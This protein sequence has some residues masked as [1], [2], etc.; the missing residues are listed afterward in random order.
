M[1]ITPRQAPSGE[2]APAG[3]ARPEPPLP[4]PPTLST[5]LLPALARPNRRFLIL[6]GIWTVVVAC[7]LGILMYY[8]ELEAR[9]IAVNRARDSYQKDLAYRRWASERGGVYVPLD[10]KTPANPHLAHRPDREI[11]TPQGKV[12]TLVNPAYMTRMVH[13]LGAV[14]YGLKGHITSLHPIRPGNAADPWERKALETF[15]QGV[16][17]ISEIT[18]QDGRRVLRF[19][20]AFL[21]E[22]SCLACHAQQGYRVGQVRGGISVT[23]P[24]GAGPAFAGLTHRSLSLLVLGTFWVLGGLAISAWIRRRRE[25]EAVQ[26]HLIRNLDE[27]S[28]QFE[29]L[30]DTTP[31]GLWF[32]DAE[33]RIRWVNDAYCRLSGYSRSELVG[34]RVS[35]VEAVESQE[36]TIRRIETMRAAPGGHRFRTRHRAKDGHFIHLEVT[37]TFVPS[38]DQI[39]AFL[40]DITEEVLSA[41]H[42]LESQARFRQLFESSPAPMYIRRGERIV[43][44]NQAIASLL[45]AERPE[46]LI[47]RSMADILPPGAPRLLA[48][49]IL[50]PGQATPVQEVLYRTLGGRQV[51]AEAQAVSLDLPEGPATLVFA[52]DLTERRH[53]EEQRRK[54]EGEIQ[55][56]QKLDSLGSLAGGIAH[57]MNNVLAAILG[58]SSLLQV[59]AG[60]D[61]ALSRSLQ[62]IEKAARRGRDLVKG[63]TDFARKDLREARILDLNALVREE[64]DL[65]ERTSRQRFTF[66]VRLEDGLPAILG[67]PSTLGSAFMNLCVNAFDAMPQGGA[68]RVRTRTE[69]SR[70]LLEVADTGH[71]IPADILPR[72]TEPFFTTKPAGRGTGLGLAMVYGAMKAHGGTLHIQSEVGKGTCIT[73]DFPSVPAGASAQPAP[74]A[75]PPAPGCSLNILV[76]DDDALIRSILPDMLGQLGHQVETA[77]S[78][79]EALRR[80]EA[81]LEADLVILDHN[82]PGLSGAETLPRILQQRPGVRVLVATGFLDNELKLLLTGFPTVQAIQKPFTLAELRRAIGGA[83]NAS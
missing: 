2:A 23:V 53:A 44:A 24:L 29:T 30:R 37:A 4:V 35:L 18:E 51:W 17:E 82:M 65:L 69:G 64:L 40:R 38:T 52:Q 74:E 76:V 81:G 21:V 22:K 36:D 15:E 14:E 27:R 42:L 10:A 20:G 9:S 16:R 58:M 59:K 77:S 26:Q 5:R 75:A 1:V 57:D 7:F 47:G 32:L 31:D 54:L 66:E 55:H 67:E 6:F 79:L 68:L 56:A 61:E 45:E 8:A 11:T 28:R 60:G 78:G 25:S 46:E 12:L 43:Q 48:E 39:A 72:I 50:L 62:T 63:L 83:P 3:F 19:M 49:A 33:A 70:V 80:L 73:L 34:E 13:E 71:G 41:Q